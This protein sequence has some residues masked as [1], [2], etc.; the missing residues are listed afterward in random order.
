MAYNSS[1]S[2][3][4]F[5]LSDEFYYFSMV[6]QELVPFL[7]NSG[8]NLDKKIE[9]CTQIISDKILLSMH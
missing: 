2:S 3:Y 5:E 8:N 9:I 6:F 1:V 4:F 7:K